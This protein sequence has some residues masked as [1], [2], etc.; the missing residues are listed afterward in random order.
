MRDFTVE[1]FDTELWHP[2]TRSVYAHWQ[3]LPRPHG[4]LPVR[5]AFDA[6]AVPAALGWIWMHDIERE[7]FRLR[8]RLFGTRI[9][10]SVGVDITGQYLQ[11]RPLSDPQRPLDAT[12][13]RLTAIDG[14]ATWARTPPILHHGDIW[15]EVESLMVPFADDGEHP[16]ILLGVSVY[17]RFDGSD[18]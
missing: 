12:R 11:D 16:D 7:P 18:V 6:F 15:S 17:Y 3:G 9:A 10:A 4:R 2:R 13:L 1:P 5:A 8:C 14:L